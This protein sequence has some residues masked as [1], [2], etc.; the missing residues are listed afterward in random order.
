MKIKSQLGKQ[1]KLKR[2]Q[3]TVCLKTVAKSCLSEHVKKMHKS[4]LRC[5]SL[6]CV[7]Y[8]Y[9]EAERLEHEVQVH[10]G[11]QWKKCIFCGKLIRSYN[12]LRHIKNLHTDV[13]IMCDFNSNCCVFFLSKS[14]KGEHILQV[15]KSGRLRRKVAYMRL[16]RQRVPRQK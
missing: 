15:H 6:R 8:F 3:C 4:I 13:A 11:V 12:F 14:E 9:T 5:K 7:S 16:L 10:S 2:T 1:F